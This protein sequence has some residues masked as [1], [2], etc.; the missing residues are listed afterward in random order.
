MMHDE[1]DSCQFVQESDMLIIIL[2]V[3]F[4][5]T[6]L[7]WSFVYQLRYENFHDV[8]YLLDLCCKLH[9]LSRFN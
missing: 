2:H 9:T 7:F 3:M 8:Y 6:L 5:S 4:T 1:S